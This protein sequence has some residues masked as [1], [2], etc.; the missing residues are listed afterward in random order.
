MRTF[1]LSLFI[2]CWFCITSSNSIDYQ[3]GDKVLRFSMDGTFKLA[4]FTDVHYGEGESESWGP[5][6]DRQSTNCMKAI[7]E[8]EE[9]DFV[10]FTGDLITGNNIY[11][12][13]TA[14]WSNMLV[15]VNESNTKF[16][17]LF[18]NHDDA[19]LEEAEASSTTTTKQQ[20]LRYQ[21][22]ISKQELQRKS[23]YYLLFLLIIYI[24]D[25]VM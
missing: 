8:M 12:N 22:I 18:G 13:A 21:N 15:A 6:Q 10:I 16:A 1:T 5:E 2:C 20:H 7:L 9:P 24:F 17:T 25:N 3:G 11:D 19:P 4:Q 14:Y 23:S